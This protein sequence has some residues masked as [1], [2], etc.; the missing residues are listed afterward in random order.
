MVAKQLYVGKIMFPIQKAYCN[1][2]VYIKANI[3]INKIS[4]NHHYSCHEFIQLF[5]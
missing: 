3:S 1:L 2:H 4:S 5:S